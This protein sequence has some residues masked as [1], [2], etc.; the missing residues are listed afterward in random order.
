MSLTRIRHD[1][2]G[3]PKLLALRVRS[4]KSVSRFQ[5]YTLGGFRINLTDKAWRDIDLW[6]GT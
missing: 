4:L 1:I 3:K 5:V 6:G 2:S